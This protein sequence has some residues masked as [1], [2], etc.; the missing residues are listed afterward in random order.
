[1]ASYVLDYFFNLFQQLFE[2]Q[3]FFVGIFQA[4]STVLLFFSAVQFEQYNTIIIH[5][6]RKHN[7]SYYPIIIWPGI[8]APL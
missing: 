6:T 3:T 5:P 2:K 8:V 7:S 1:M 4:T